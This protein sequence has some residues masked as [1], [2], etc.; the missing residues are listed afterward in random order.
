M[1]GKKAGKRMASKGL[2]PAIY[3]EKGNLSS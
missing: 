2:S 1:G 3:R